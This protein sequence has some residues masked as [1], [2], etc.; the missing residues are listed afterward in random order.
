MN[1]IGA[2]E[3]DKLPDTVLMESDGRTLRTYTVPI[4]VKKLCVK[5]FRPQ[6]QN[7]LT[8][9]WFKKFG[10]SPSYANSAGMAKHIEPIL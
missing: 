1:A 6:V 10:A 8:R 9:F 4:D 7:F 2:I 3:E 5:K